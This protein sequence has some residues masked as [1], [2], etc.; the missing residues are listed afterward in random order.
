MTQEEVEN[1]K[2]GDTLACKISPFER[3][4]VDIAYSNGAFGMTIM[5][6]SKYTVTFNP[7]DARDLKDLTENWKLVK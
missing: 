6:D 2:V 4:K 1:I 3:G 5:H 7:T